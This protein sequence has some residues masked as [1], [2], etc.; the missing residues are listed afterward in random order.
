[1]FPRAFSVE[2]D[3]ACVRRSIIKDDPK[4]FGLK[5]CRKRKI[6]GGI[7][8]RVKIRSLMLYIASLRRL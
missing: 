4:D 8:L 5:N 6:A 7:H 3:I 1:M 2:L